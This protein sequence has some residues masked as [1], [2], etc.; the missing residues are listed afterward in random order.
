[1]HKYKLYKVTVEKEFVVAAPEEHTLQ[2]VEKSIDSIMTIHADSLRDEG[3]SHV[4]AEEIKTLGELPAG[5]VPGC[6]PYTNHNYVNMPE[7]LV[8]LPISEYL[9]ENATN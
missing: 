7:E 3:L 4:L 1:M 5:W 8:N 6:L 2:E 9:K